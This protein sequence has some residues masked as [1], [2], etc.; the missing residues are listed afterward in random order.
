MKV[1]IRKGVFETNSSSTHSIMIQA[2]GPKQPE[3]WTLKE[4]LDQLR[5]MGVTV[6]G[7][8]DK[9]AGIALDFGSMDPEM[10]EFHRTEE[11]YNTWGM[12][13]L[14]AIVSF[15]HNDFLWGG[16]LSY[17][18]KFHIKT[19][20]LKHE[21]NEYYREGDSFG[22]IDHDSTGALAEIFSNGLSFED[23]LERKDVYLVIDNEG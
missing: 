9:I 14:Y 23:Y 13:L 2:N 20:Y 8:E 19:L 21:Y 1:T 15:M 6:T 17:L 12:K 4:G 10:A 16:V 5:A 18:R 11:A 7:D 22:H 3:R